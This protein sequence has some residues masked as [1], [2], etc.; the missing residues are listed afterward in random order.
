MT[1]APGS[2]RHTDSRVT[3]N[4]IQDSHCSRGQ[5]LFVSGKGIRNGQ[6]NCVSRLVFPTGCMAS[7]KLPLAAVPTITSILLHAIL[8][9]IRNTIGEIQVRPEM[10]ETNVQSQSSLVFTTAAMCMKTGC[11]GS[12]TGSDEK[13]IFILCPL[14][15]ECHC[16]SEW[17]LAHWFRDEGEA[18]QRRDLKRDDTGLCGWLFGQVHAGWFMCTSSCRSPGANIDGLFLRAQGNREAAISLCFLF[19]FLLRPQINWTPQ[20]ANTPDREQFLPQL[21]HQPP[22]NFREQRG[23]KS[24]LIANII[25]LSFLFTDVSTQEGYSN[26]IGALALLPSQDRPPTV[27]PLRHFCV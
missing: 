24:N 20:D 6:A 16:S 14:C 15:R 17:P 11:S 23:G 8:A 13:V 19:F 22:P 9:Y 21:T 27:K 18:P 10:G 25:D 26:Y 1:A 5:V 2:S 7:I 4:M 3:K 12:T